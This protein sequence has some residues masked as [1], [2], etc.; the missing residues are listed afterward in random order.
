MENHLEDSPPGNPAMNLGLGL[1]QGLGFRSPRGPGEQATAEG[2]S[3]PQQGLL[4]GEAG[5]TLALLGPTAEGQRQETG[6]SAIELTHQPLGGTH[7]GI[8]IAAPARLSH[9]VE[10]AL[11]GHGL[12]GEAAK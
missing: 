10:V 12:K 8:L 2:A 1:D 5:T 6:V 3:L 7:E 11:Q 4:L 9:L